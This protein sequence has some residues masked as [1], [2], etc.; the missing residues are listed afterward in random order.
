[1]D[2]PSLNLRPR[3]LR[4]A[5]FKK[6]ILSSVIVQVKWN[7]EFLLQNAK[8]NPIQI[9]SNMKICWFYTFQV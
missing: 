6:K 5:P 2:L 9:F 3:S 7:A 8:K 1:M 4:K